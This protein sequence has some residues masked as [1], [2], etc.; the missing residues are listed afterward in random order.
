ML[1]SLPDGTLPE[2]CDCE[3]AFPNNLAKLAQLL[4]AG[5]TTEA[6]CLQL[7]VAT[8]KLLEGQ[9]AKQQYE[10]LTFHCDWAVHSEL[11]GPAAQKILKLFDA[12]NTI[13]RKGLNLSD[14][15]PALRTKIERISKMY[16]FEE[17]LQRF[18]QSNNLPDIEST[19]PDGWAHFL[20]LYAKIVEHTPLVMLQMNKSPS[21]SSVSLSL[22]LANR[23]LNGDMLFKVT[24]TILD[25]N[26]LSGDIF[27]LH[28]FSLESEHEKSTT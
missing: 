23:L 8:R 19:R 25:R 18:L 3:V 2:R 22:E 1:S 15:P 10:F 26:G 27:V 24:W 7:I 4:K 13:L 14:L 11:T 12:A 16:V 5:I 9:K 20:H 17:E 28:S 6:E 21:I